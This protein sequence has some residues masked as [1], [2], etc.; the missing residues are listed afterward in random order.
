MTH[1][2]IKHMAQPSRVVNPD[3]EK[4][5]DWA[6]PDPERFSGLDFG[7]FRIFF[8]DW[9]LGLGWGNFLKIAKKFKNAT[10]INVFTTIYIVSQFSL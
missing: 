9:T 2:K 8:R 5:R 7:D 6:D 4:S 3:P 10:K 1:A